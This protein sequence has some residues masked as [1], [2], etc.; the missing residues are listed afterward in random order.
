MTR[1]QAIPN[2][3]FTPARSSLRLVSIY[4]EL[5]K[6]RLSAM[7]VFTAAA[8]FIVASPRPIDAAVFTAMVIGVALAAFSANALNQCLEAERDGRMQ[9]TAGRPLP[10]GL[11][12]L[13]HATAYGLVCGAIG[14]GLLALA[15]GALPALL[16]AAN[17]V[18]YVLI[19]TP[20][21]TRSTLNTIAGAVVGAVPP[22]IGWSAATGS[23]ALGAWILAAVLFVWQVPH[24][25]ALA[26]MYR[27]DYERGG[28]RMLP[29]ID[30]TGRLTARM[31][32]LWAVA[33]LPVA[34]GVTLIGDAGWIYAAGSLALGGYMTMLGWGLIRRVDHQRARRLFFASVMYLPLLLGLM[35]L[36]RSGMT[37]IAG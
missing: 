34:L 1:I 30:P 23:L 25:L 3:R 24:F 8:G 35:V 9:R 15:T 13:T 36:D 17:I 18:W 2:R 33:L 7:V 27:D 10:A 32:C 6:A 16:A 22:M 29:A 37:L 26:W 19:Y 12:G 11:I 4:L 21:K 28:Y 20:M 14:V 5:G 31:A